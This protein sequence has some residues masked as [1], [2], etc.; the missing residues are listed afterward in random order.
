MAD[1]GKNPI[2]WSFKSHLQTKYSVVPKTDLERVLNN[3]LELVE[4]SREMKH[5]VRSIL[6]LAARMIFKLFDFDEIGIGLKNPK[7]GLYRYE[8]LFGYSRDTEMAFR[9]LE[10]AHED[11]VSYDR[12]PFVKIGG[13]S[14]LDPVEGIPEGE[15]YL[16]ERPSAVDLPR[17]SPD[18]FHEGDYI[19][20]WM[21]DGKRDLIGWFELSK[22]RNGKMPTCDTVRWVELIVE[23]CGLI[24]ER[25]R[26]DENTSRS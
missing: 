3:I 2:D 13:I 23:I 11:M 18:D 20:V 26:K 19:D 4:L 6:E 16:Y 14:E 12:Y 8:V 7:D 5:D 17:A 9:K 22:P 21:Y 1:R 24:V 10:Y 25:K 15:K